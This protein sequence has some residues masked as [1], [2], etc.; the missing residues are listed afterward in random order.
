MSKE[1]NTTDTEIK[2]SKKKRSKEVKDL[3]RIRKWSHPKLVFPGAEQEEHPEGDGTRLDDPAG[4]V[5]SGHGAQAAADAAEA[6]RW[7]HAA[8]APDGAGEPG[9]VQRPTAER[10]AQETHHGA[11]AAAQRPQGAWSFLF[12]TLCGHLVSWYREQTSNGF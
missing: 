5:H 9:G 12:A 8:A 11:A 1:D 4:R 6:T 10:A 3:C 2:L 7:A